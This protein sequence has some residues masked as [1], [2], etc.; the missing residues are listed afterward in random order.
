MD[1]MQK[2]NKTLDIKTVCECCHCLGSKARTS[3]RR[4]PRGMNPHDGN[5][6][7]QP[8]K[9]RVSTNHLAGH[10]DKG[11]AVGFTRNQRDFLLSLTSC[12]VALFLPEALFMCKYM[13]L[14]GAKMTSCQRAN[15]MPY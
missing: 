12:M 1:G 7:L 4:V 5:F 13:I 8:G 2:D 6:G 3:F 15:S 10:D 9:V 14:K 11:S